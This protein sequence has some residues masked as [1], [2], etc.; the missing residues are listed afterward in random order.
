[1]SVSDALFKRFAIDV[2]DKIPF[3]LAAEVF[4]VYAQIAPL[5]DSGA[6]QGAATATVEKLRER[7]Q[8]LETKLEP[9][10]TQP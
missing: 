4:D 5:V 9:Y 2:A 1:V 3:A 7:L 10:A 8:G 6:L